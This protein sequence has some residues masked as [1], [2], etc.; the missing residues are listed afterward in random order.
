MSWL[1][2]QGKLCIIE[3]YNIGV[4]NMPWESDQGFSLVLTH[5][6]CVTLRI[7]LRL[8][9]LICKTRNGIYSWGSCEDSMS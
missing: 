2:Y 5:T 4:M 6:G 1:P 9:F 8:S 7:I 3:E